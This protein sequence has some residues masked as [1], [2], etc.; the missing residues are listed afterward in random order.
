MTSYEVGPQAILAKPPVP[1]GERNEDLSDSAGYSLLFEVGGGS[2][3][4]IREPQL[5]TSLGPGASPCLNASQGP[6]LN[7][8][9]NPVV[10][11][12]PP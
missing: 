11:G 5:A 7:P 1:H 8:V 9:V 3:H 2:R 6:K 12:R 4:T 10:R